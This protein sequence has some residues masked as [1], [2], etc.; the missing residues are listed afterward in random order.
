MLQFFVF[1]TVGKLTIY[2]FQKSPYLSLFKWRFLKELFECD[3]CLGVW[4]YFI[5]AIIF[6]V[7]LFSSN[8]IIIEYIFTGAVTSFLVWVFSAGWN[9]KFSV[10]EIK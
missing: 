7:N 6:R 3:L 8:H 2:L 5:L 10:M 4:I 9:E 1:A